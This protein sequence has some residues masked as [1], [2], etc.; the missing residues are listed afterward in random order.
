MNPVTSQDDGARPFPLVGVMALFS[1]VGLLLGI[2]RLEQVVESWGG[3]GRW[4]LFAIAVYLM[5][6]GVKQSLTALKPDWMVSRLPRWSRH[7]MAATSEGIV[8]IAIMS[9]MFIGSILGRSNMLMVVFAMMIGPWVINGWIAFSVL[10]KTSV[11][12]RLPRRAMAGELVSIE[13]EVANRKWLLSSW[14][15]AARDHIAHPR[16]RFQAAALFVRIPARQQRRGYYLVRFSQRGVYSFGPIELTKH[17]PLGLV[18]RG[19]LCDEL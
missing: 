15:L 17:F 11:K 14:L 8:Y 10:K 19:L 18:E 3:L 12:R 5:L 1:G 7:R 13:L 2:K 6:W 4:V 9:V 16:D